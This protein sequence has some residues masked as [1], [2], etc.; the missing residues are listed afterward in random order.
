MKLISSS[1]KSIEN[2]EIIKRKDMRA[3]RKQFY[4]RSEGET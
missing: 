4:V 3:Y 2:E 1:D